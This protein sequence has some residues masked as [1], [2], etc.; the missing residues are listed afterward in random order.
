MNKALQALID[1]ILLAAGTVEL[2]SP[3]HAPPATSARPQQH[4]REEASV[5]RDSEVKTA[6]PPERLA[7]KQAL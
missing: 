3:N 6:R 5:D 7:G 4:P 2:G 1:A